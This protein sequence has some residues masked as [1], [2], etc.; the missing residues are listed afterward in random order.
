M[1][2]RVVL[3][4]LFIALFAGTAS[5]QTSSSASRWTFGGAGGFGSTSDDEGSIG[6]GV[7]AGGYADWR[8]L[9]HTDVELSVDY[10]R[11][12]R[13]TG[14]FQAEGHTTF[15]SAALV[16][17]FG[18]DAA[19]GFVFGGVTLGSHAGSAGFPADNLVSENKGTHPGFTLGG[20]LMFRASERIHVGPVVRVVFLTAESDSD[21]FAA[22]M[23]GVRVGFR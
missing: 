16:Q 9:G 22:G 1:R 15:L 11:H 5:A 23:A 4:G 14:F 19:Y 21:V 10:L 13:S 7:L 20:G 6:S 8:W 2:T 12:K 3:V 17:R 18:G